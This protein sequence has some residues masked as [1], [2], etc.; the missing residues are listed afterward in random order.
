MFSLVFLL[1]NLTSIVNLI[2]IIFFK[3]RYGSEDKLATLMGVMQ[4]LVSVVQ[5]GK[6]TIRLA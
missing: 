6:N 3:C 5:D 2:F 1:P 4:A